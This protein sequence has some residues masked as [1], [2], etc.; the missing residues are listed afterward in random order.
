MTRTVHQLLPV[1]ADGDAIGGHVR[2]AADVLQRAGY[3]TEIFYEDAH[4]PVRKLGR[5]FTELDVEAA[6][7]EGAWLLYHLSTGTTKGM[8]E[9][10]LTSGIPFGVYF[11]NITP[12]EFFDR[13]EPG[14]AENLRRAKAEMRRIA[15]G[16]RFAMANSSFSTVELERDGFEHPSVVPVL[17]DLSTDAVAPNE[18]ML[19]RLRR[20]TSEGG[21][22][23]L[24]VGRVAPN[25]CQHDVIAA[26]AVYRAAYDP[27]ARLTLVGGR[28]SNLY[29]RTLELLAAELGVADAVELT[30]TIS[31]AEREAC[32]RAADVFVCLSEHEGFAVPVLEAMRVDVPVVAL[33]AGAVPETAADGAVLLEGKDPVLV[34]A[35][36]HQVMT[37][38][39]LRASL[40][41]AGRRRVE[42]YSLER[43]S[44]RFLAALEEAL[45][46][47]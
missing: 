28:T 5:P 34:A 23:W 22:R 43:T 44:K 11:H 25:K 1:F 4:P 14:A 3:R 30:D 41:E 36:V 15:T 42:E 31:D 8:G 24:F 46:A 47:A 29:Y 39:G 40:V 26:F 33:A 37:D 6:K 35:A 10:L 12:P 16:S 32:Y 45:D 13:W 7:R 17:S 38:G 20:E 19:S 27:K 9:F 18:R 2:R 21:S